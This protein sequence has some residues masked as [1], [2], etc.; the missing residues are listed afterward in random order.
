MLSLLG[1]EMNMIKR[2]NRPWAV[3]WSAPFNSARAMQ[4]L[5]PTTKDAR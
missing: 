3:Q 5:S 1:S 4:D 2:R